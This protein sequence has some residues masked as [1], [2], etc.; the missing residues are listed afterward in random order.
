MKK[1]LFY[2]GFILSISS[3]VHGAAIDERK[4]DIY[5]GNGVWNNRQSAVIGQLELEDFIIYKLEKTEAQVKLA[6]NHTNGHRRDL[7][8]TYYQLYQLGQISFGYFTAL[9]LAMTPDVPEGMLPIYL[10]GMISEETEDLDVMVNNYVQNIEDGHTVLLVSHSQG[11]LFGLRAFDNLESWQK[12]Y[13]LQF[14]VASPGNRVANEGEWVT[15]TNDLVIKKLIDLTLIGE[16]SLDANVTIPITSSDFSGH[17]F[18]ATYLADIDSVNKIKGALE[19]SFERLQKVPSQWQKSAE[20]GCGCDKRIEV[21][22][23]YDSFLNEL[24]EGR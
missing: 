22:H 16:D 9:S 3:L 8:E 10:A 14:S 19:R 23:K 13:F 24:M 18:I 5:F 11:N 15:N 1:I 20:I 7:I 17:E 21:E 2:I 12:N 6:F 4:T